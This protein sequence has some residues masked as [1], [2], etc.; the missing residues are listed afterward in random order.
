MSKQKR[1]IYVGDW[2][3]LFAMIIILGF[4]IV[5]FIIKSSDKAIMDDLVT[6]FVAFL[7]VFFTLLFITGLIFLVKWLT[8]REKKP[9]EAKKIE[10]DD[11]ELIAVITAAVA[12]SMGKARQARPEF[13]VREYKSL[14][15]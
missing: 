12:S 8:D 15:Q 4:L 5:Y 7:A 9:V 6:G 3:T 1:R 13:V 10:V 11:S 14:N 2:I